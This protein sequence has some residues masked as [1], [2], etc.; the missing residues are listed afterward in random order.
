MDIRDKLRHLDS[1]P[2]VRKKPSKTGLRRD[3]ERFVNGEERTNEYG[4]YF[5]SANLYPESQTHGRV[6]LD[7]IRE[8][9]P[10]LMDWIGRDPALKDAELTAAVYLDTETTGLA[11]G[12]GTLPFLVGLGSFTEGGF[13]VEQFFMRDYDEEQAV[14][15]AVR[16]RLGEAGALVTYNGKA[17]D[18]NILDAR[19]TLSRMS[20]PARDLPHLDLLFSVRRLW[21][22]R[23]SDC[24]LVNVEKEILRF[25]RKDDVPG[26]LIPG[27]YFEY[28]RSRS[29]VSLEPV[30]TH[31]RWDIIALA[32][33]AALINRIYQNPGDMLEH[34]ADLVSLGRAMENLPQTRAAVECFIKALE[35]EPDPDEKG[36]IYRSLG[37][38]WKRLGEWEKAVDI[39][40]EMIDSQPYSTLPYEE[41]A[42]YYEHRTREFE[43]AIV[44]VQ[45]A[46][47]RL[48]VME[49]L[50]TER[51]VPSDRQDLEYRLR[52]LK[53]KTERGG[54]G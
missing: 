38:A 27:L 51:T 49:A 9:D 52:R 54:T 36:E 10:A 26:F 48:A 45:R 17:Y 32:A 16:E 13:L 4:R 24:S 25:F 39:W 14:L 7:S 43:R 28:L 47:D 2:G 22:R 6:S 3:I 30:F 29:A 34:S 31:N 37:L 33:L 44:V 46:L 41:L 21:R 12:T 20:H 19:W 40:N 23:L 8:S 1:L 15:H 53:R 18:L 35:S 11:G 5:Y 42:K 50:H